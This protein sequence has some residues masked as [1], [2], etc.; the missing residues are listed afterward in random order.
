[1]GHEQLNVRLPADIAEKF[2][3][4]VKRQGLVKQ[5]LVAKLIEAWLGRRKLDAEAQESIRM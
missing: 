5:H 4:E 1:M 3:A 2:T